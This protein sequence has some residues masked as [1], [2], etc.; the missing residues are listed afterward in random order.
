MEFSQKLTNKGQ[1]IIELLVVMALMAML[2]PVL[3]GGFITSREGRPQQQNQSNASQIIMSAKQAMFSIRESGWDNI[4]TNGIYHIEEDSGGS[5]DLVAGSNTENGFT[6]E[7]IISDIYRNSSN[8]IVEST[9]GNVDP[10]TKKIDINV[11][12][13]LPSPS[14]TSSSFYLTRYMDNATYIQTSVADFETGTHSGTAVGNSDGGEVLLG[15]GGRGDWCKPSTSVVAELD[16]PDNAR[17]KD[18]KA[19]EGKAFTGTHLGS[20]GTF[21]EI[22]LDNQYPPTATIESVLNGYE[23]NDVYIDGDY[24]YVATGDI[25]RDV[26]IIDLNTLQEVGYFNDSSWF[27]T[28]QGIVVKDN[29]GYVTIGLKLHTFDLSSK[30]GS[31]PELDSEYL[32]W[33]FATGYRLEVVNGYAYVAV[34]YGSS[35]MRILDVTNPN[36]IKNVGYANVNGARGQEVWVNETGTRAYLATDHSS[37]KDELFIINTE[38]KN[39]SRPIIG[40]YDSQGMSPTGVAIGTGNKAILVGRNGHEYQAIDISNE[41]NPVLCGSL[42]LDDGIYGVSTVLEQ[43]GDAYSY[44]VTSDIDAEFKVIV[45]GPGI[46]YASS[47]VYESASFNAGYSTAFNR[48]IPKQTLPPNTSIKYHVAVADEVSGSCE[49]ANYIFVGP[50]KTASTF[51]TQEALIPFDDDSLGYENPGK[52][53]RYRAYLETADSSST[54]IFEESIINY[55]P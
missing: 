22:S 7:I 8:E 2:L 28:A 27:G 24:A 53:F 18:V 30:T 33:F 32:Y 54:P 17:A 3:I 46:S 50:D 49:N 40:S 10:S 13:S 11:S 14:S 12:W 15:A 43:D 39:G 42:D 9:Q 55:S 21:V 23:T 1:S 36:K 16:L 6:T 4:S 34:D 31:R 45:G 19:R 48:F 25:S 41:N 20:G 5:W 35:E 47:G 29:V 51:Y 44:V 38:N 37:S 52:C 26:I